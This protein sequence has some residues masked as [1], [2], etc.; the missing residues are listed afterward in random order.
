MSQCLNDERLQAVMDDE[1]HEDELEHVRSCRRCASEVAARRQAVEDF[2]REMSRVTVPSRLGSQVAAAL[3]S[4]ADRGGATTLRRHTPS[5]RPVRT[6][7]FAAGAATAAV[8]VLVFVLFPSIDR[9]TRLNAAAIL[10]RSIETLSRQGVEALRYDLTVVAPRSF[11]IE[12]GTYRIEQLIDHETGR[13]RMAR[14]APDGTLLNGISE[15]PSARTREV[16]LRDSGRTFRF[17]LALAERDSLH[18]WNV[19][20]RV[21]ES[22]I[23]LVQ[24]AAGHVI[25]EQGSGDQ[26]RYVVELPEAVSDGNAHLFDLTRAR[27]VVDASDFHI[28]EFTASGSVMGEPLSIGFHLDSWLVGASITPDSVFSLP[29]ADASTIELV[30]SATIDP[31]RDLVAAL[32]REV[33]RV[34]R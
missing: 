21:A 15:D 12:T 29:P 5:A 10:K 27:V 32:L 4:A 33:A 22:M 23:R 31:A 7:L 16:F 30:G 14:F 1:A 11:P 17:R 28:V 13:W 19:Q 3:A 20:R 2:G 25:T 26:R 24:A 8:I 18:L 6:W 9:G 34:S